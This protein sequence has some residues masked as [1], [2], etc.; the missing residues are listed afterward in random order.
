MITYSLYAF[1]PRVR[2]AAEALAESGHQIDVFAI[3]REGMTASNDNGPL[4]IRLLRMRKKQAGLARH[5]FEYGVFFSWVFVLVSL[6]H[7]R[8]RYDVVYVHN[9]PNFLVFAGLF[10]KIGGAKIVLDVHDPAAELLAAIRG[11]D[12]P[13]RAQRLANA[14]E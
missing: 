1:D 2:R 6:L 5:A 14:E 13:P 8:R 7:A 9:M 11:R 4:R 12:L 3:C 10:P